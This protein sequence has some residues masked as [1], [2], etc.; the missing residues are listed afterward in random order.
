MTKL[1]VDPCYVV[2]DDKWHSSITTNTKYRDNQFSMYD[3]KKLY[4]Y[5]KL[6]L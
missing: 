6:Y 3:Y 2:E 5:R 1:E 4:D